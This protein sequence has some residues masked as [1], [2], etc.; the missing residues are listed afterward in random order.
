MTF[1]AKV[2]CD[3]CDEQY[4]VGQAD[5]IPEG[6]SRIDVVNDGHDIMEQFHLCPNC[7]SLKDPGSISK[8]INA[9]RALADGE[10][11][12]TP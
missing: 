12:G 8:V 11:D 5:T 9:D 4:E 7:D 6:W 3:G 2:Q 10:S 1:S